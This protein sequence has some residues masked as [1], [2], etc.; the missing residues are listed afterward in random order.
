[1]QRVIAN[2]VPYFT[3][4]QNRLFTWDTEATPQLIG[5]HNPTDGTVSY[6]SNHLD[7]LAVRLQV[8]REKQQPRDRKATTATNGGRAT[9]G[10]ASKPAQNLEDDE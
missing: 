7:S 10:G 3:D 1:M 8:W 2:G 6:E 5:T 9:R 4:N